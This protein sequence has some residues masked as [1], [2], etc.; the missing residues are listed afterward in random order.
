MIPSINETH[1]NLKLDRN[2]ISLYLVVYDY[3]YYGFIYV[4]NDFKLEIIDVLWNFLKY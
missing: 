4:T 1:G 3:Y 2:V